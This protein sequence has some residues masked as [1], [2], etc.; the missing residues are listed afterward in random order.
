[1]ARPHPDFALV[2]ALTADDAR[3][4]ELESMFA[5]GSNL[6]GPRAN[7]ALAAAFADCIAAEGVTEPQWALLTEWLAIAEDE[8]PT[9]YPREFLPFCATQAL[10]A[11]YP[12]ASR[13]RRDEIAAR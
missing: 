9:G 11:A 4:D 2:C 5:S 3:F 7:L 12:T 6:P 13:E 10:G 1:M 8:A